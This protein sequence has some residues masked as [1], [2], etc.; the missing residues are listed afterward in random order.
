MRRHAATGGK[1][2]S[3]LISND[4]PTS[5][6]PYTTTKTSKAQ[7][8]IMTVNNSMCVIIALQESTMAA[9]RCGDGGVAI[10]K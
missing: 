1:V 9:A 7:A 2:S 3:V 6:E 10:K 5:Q 4:C 8:L